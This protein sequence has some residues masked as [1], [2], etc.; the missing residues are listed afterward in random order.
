MLT[1]TIP[2]P[3]EITPRE[4]ERSLM[5]Y[6]TMFASSTVG[7]PL[8]FINFLAALA[9][10]HYIKETSAYVRFHSYQSLFSQL[11]TSVFNLV[12]IIWLIVCFINQD[13]THGFIA[14]G[15]SAL[16]INFVYFIISIIA[17]VK[18]YKGQMF[19]FYFFG[20]I[21]FR[22]AFKKYES[23]PKPESLN[24]PPEV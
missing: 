8:P 1:S 24:V 10:H 21:S 11:V 3:S 12:A 15:I 5:A 2:Q 14:F 18:A 16:V 6:M 17:A 4:R 13:F 23:S 9:F 7:L 20:D 22:K 19:Y